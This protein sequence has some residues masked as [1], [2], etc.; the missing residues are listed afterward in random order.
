M[1]R[2]STSL[3][4]PSSALPPP[5]GEIEV[6]LSRPSR[7][8]RPGESIEGKIITN[9][10]SAISYHK[11][12]VTATGT[13]NLQVRGGVTGVIESLYSVVKP[14]SILK[15]S[16]DVT[17]PAG[18]LGPGKTEVPFSFVLSSEDIDNR[19]RIYE[20]FH[21]GNISIQYLITADITR[22][23][24]H[25]SLSATVEFIV[26]NDNA[27]LLV[28]SASPELVT[29]YITQDTQKHQLLPEL[30]IGHFCV[31]GKIST[32]CSL[33]DP[34]SGELTVETS[35]VPIKSI[36]IQL[37]R[38]ES[39]LAGERII[40]DASVVQTTQIA[41]GDVCRSMTL[42]IFVLLPRLL[43]CPTV[44]AGSFSVEFQVSIV[45]SFQS[46]LAK[47]Y[48][49]SDLRTPRPWLAMVTLPLRLYRAR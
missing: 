20:T 18:R 2:S 42:P 27:S 43:V 5:L 14:I 30:Q 33:A 22:G 10:S 45:I 15:R 41:D 26:E 6:K 47:L 29:F 25:K 12:L 9:S 35:A 1:P 40:S 31:T 13:V 11:I 24:L 36:D 7:I 37:L 34:L 23:Y 39:I 49:K 8:Y 48:P 17:A 38:V 4:S 46:E 44:L 16:I 19:G 28:S 32:Q 3:S 21:G